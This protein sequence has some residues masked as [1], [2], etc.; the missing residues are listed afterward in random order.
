MT[1]SFVVRR[2][3]RH[4]APIWEN[5]NRAIG[6]HV[7]LGPYVV[8]GR[9]CRVQ[10]CISGCEDRVGP[11]VHISAED[12]TRVRELPSSSEIVGISLEFG[13]EFQESGPPLQPCLHSAGY[14]LDVYDDERNPGDP[15]ARLAVC[16][17]CHPREVD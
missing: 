17:R 15:R 13:W 7:L 5:P 16:A 1:P 2:V 3:S 14:R 10:R 11:H 4:H 9:N 12:P 8:A 6:P